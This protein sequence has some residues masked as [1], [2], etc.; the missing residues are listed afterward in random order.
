MNLME[1]A[2]DSMDILRKNSPKILLFGGIG[3]GVA[4]LG[5]TSFAS[6]KASEI[7]MNTHKDPRARD[8]KWLAKQYFTKILPL[9][10][11]VAV[12]EAGSVIC[13]VK[14][15]DI[16]A[17][18][19]AAATALAEVSVETLRIYRDKAKEVLGKEKAEELEKEVRSQKDDIHEQLEMHG[20][21]HTYIVWFKDELTGQDF[22]STKEKI[23]EAT[24][25]LNLR[26]HSQMN[27]SLNEWIGILN[28]VSLSFSNDNTFQLSEVLNGEDCGWE[29]G[30]PIYVH[31]DETGVTKNGLPCFKLVYSLPPK[32][33]HRHIYY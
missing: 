21:P 28:D 19:L 8:K 3:L 20:D 1:T 22:L 31:Y 23:N 4:A 14:S 30:Y 7:V 26:L 24:L 29:E 17:K 5:M 15:Y 25:E 6:F 32:P 2:N 27:V 11:P 13:L 9:Y 16:S 33:N 10:V 18:R 12:L